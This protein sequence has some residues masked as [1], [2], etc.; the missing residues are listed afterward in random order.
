MPEYAVLQPL[1]WCKLP[2]IIEEALAPFPDKFENL[3]VS[4]KVKSTINDAQ[5][6]M[7]DMC[8]RSGVWKRFSEKAKLHVGFRPINEIDVDEDGV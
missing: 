3:E 8:V 5:V 4:V 1:T 7:A 6:E 2:H